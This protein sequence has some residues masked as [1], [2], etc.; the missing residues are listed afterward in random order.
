MAAGEGLDLA[1]FTGLGL[2][3]KDSGAEGKATKKRGW[4]TRGG[5]KA[6]FTATDSELRAEGGQ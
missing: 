4:R 1:N 3:R 5:P 2:Q 6:L